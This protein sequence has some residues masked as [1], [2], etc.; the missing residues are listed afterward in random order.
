M[1]QSHEGFEALFDVRHDDQ[2]AHDGVGRL[3]GNDSGLGDP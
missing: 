3:G 2:L 1:A